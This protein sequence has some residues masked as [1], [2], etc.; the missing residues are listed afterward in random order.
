MT[1][2]EEMSLSFGSQ[3]SVYETAR[4]EYPSEAVAFLLEPVLGEAGA[5]VADVGAGTGKLT[6]AVK[7]LGDI[8]VVAIDPDGEMLRELRKSLPETGTMIG[9]AEELPLPDASRDAVVLGQAWH[10]V[11]PVRG[12]AEIGR[13]VREGGVLGLI[14]NIRDASVPWVRRLTDIMHSSNAE[15]LIDDEGGPVVAAPFGP[16][17]RAD[18]TWTRPIT[19]DGLLNLARSRSYLITATPED[20]ARIESELEVFF[21][22]LGLEGDTTIDLPYR[23]VAFRSIRA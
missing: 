23:T 13:V 22:E 18:F 3:A 5:R 21:D 19:R 8:D 12:S 4:P 10:W 17:E 16:L 14:W 20:R 6:K 7:A 2:R 1:S 15:I 9:M 11:D